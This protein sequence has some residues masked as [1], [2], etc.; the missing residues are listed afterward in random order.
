MTTNLRMPRV[1]KD[2]NHDHKL[3]KMKSRQRART[4]ANLRT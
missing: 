1:E 4:T 3:E 2:K